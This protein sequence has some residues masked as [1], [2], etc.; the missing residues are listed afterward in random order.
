M[1]RG[2]IGRRIR[3]VR[4]ALGLRL[5][6]LSARSDLSLSQLSKIETGK[7]EPTIRGLVRIAT[8]LGR[9]LTF[10]LQTEAEIPRSLATLMPFVGPES[11]AVRTLA[12]SVE[13][14]SGG[15]MRIEILA[16]AQIDRFA[17]VPDTLLS[18][19]IDMLI[20][21]LAFY[22][23]H[24]EAI[25]PASLPFC[26]RGPAHHEAFLGSDVFREGVVETLLNKGVRFLDPHWRWRRAPQVL[27]SR[28]P[29]F[30]VRDLHHARVR[31]YDSAVLRH[32][33]EAFGARPVFVPWLETADA[34]RSGDV[35]CVAVSA[36]LLPTTGF[37]A[38]A[39]YVTV[40][41]LLDAMVT[42]VNVGINEERYQLLQPEAQALLTDAVSAAGQA[43]TTALGGGAEAA[44][45]H[46]VD[47]DGAV[48]ARVDLRPFRAQAGV[49]IRELEQEG[50]W[51]AGLVEAIQAVGGGA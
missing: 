27:V 40:V 39:K 38:V 25:V 51:A 17:E 9:P 18:G 50:R 48:V 11:D 26:F 46:C 34:L 43:V 45:T 21:G 20:E 16:A 28:R 24:A 2:R 44:L 10:F 14:R 15:R 8:A 6:D 31:I 35:E 30:R 23:S 19:A 49:V 12:R 7:A 41:D 1:D 37:T 42:T 3:E 13:E 5:L 32:F 22:Q 47:R 4:K 36:G 33:W 29:L